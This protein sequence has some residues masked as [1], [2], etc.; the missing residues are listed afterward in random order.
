E[1]RRQ[2]TED[3]RQKTEDRRQKTEDRRVTPSPNRAQRKQHSLAQ[4]KQNNARGANK[5]KKIRPPPM[6]NTTGEV[7]CDTLTYSEAATS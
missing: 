3:R 6:A 7:T 4:D 2:K 1:D 5:S